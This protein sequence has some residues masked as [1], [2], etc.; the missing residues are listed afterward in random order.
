MKVHSSLIL[1]VGVGFLDRMCRI[2]HENVGLLFSYFCVLVTFLKI[3]LH[4]LLQH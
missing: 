2:G 3:L 4:F 1:Y